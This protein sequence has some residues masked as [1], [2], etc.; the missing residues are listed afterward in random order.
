LDVDNDGWLDAFAANGAVRTLEGEARANEPFPFHQR[1]QLLRNSSDGQFADVTDRG[2][3][4][5]ASSEVGRGVAFGD[6]DNDG[7][8]DIVVS[9]DNGPLRL[10]MNQIR[11]GH[12]WM[13]LRLVGGRGPRDLLGASV[14][15]ARPGVPTLFR[16]ARTDGSYASA[17]DPRVLVGLGSSNVRP[18]VRVTWPDGSQERW[19]SLPYDQYVTLKQGTA[20]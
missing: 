7:R 17:N 3:P 18:D 20:R 12:H 13:G 5:F 4:P 19:T 10:F 2:G 11:N 8:M 6:I 14:E 16:R 9:N 1:R 15:I